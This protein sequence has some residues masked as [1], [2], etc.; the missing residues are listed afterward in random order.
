MHC[1][2]GACY[3]TCGDGVHDGAK[4][5]LPAKVATLHQ[6]HNVCEARVW[7]EGLALSTQPQ[8]LWHVGWGGM[9]QQLNSF[10]T[11]RVRLAKYLVFSPSAIGLPAGRY[12][13][14]CWSIGGVGGATCHNAS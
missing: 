5:V 6:L 13:V 8:H 3:L 11:G 14:A 2:G 9:V 1:T 4:V 7:G 12:S 10:V